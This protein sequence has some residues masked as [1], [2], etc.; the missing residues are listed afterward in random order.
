MTPTTTPADRSFRAR[1]R[2]VLPEGS[3]RHAVVDS[4]GAHRYIDLPLTVVIV[5]AVL[6]PWLAAIGA[7]VAVVAGCSIRVERHGD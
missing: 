1:L 4:K 5:G 6:A 7:V 3:V 2:Y